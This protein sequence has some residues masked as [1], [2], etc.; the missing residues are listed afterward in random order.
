MAKFI[1]LYDLQNRKLLIAVDKIS[2]I[3][4]IPDNKNVI[5]VYTETTGFCVRGNLDNIIKA[6]EAETAIASVKHGS[7]TLDEALTFEKVHRR[8]EDSSIL[9][10]AKDVRN[11][12]DKEEK[13]HKCTGNCKSKLIEAVVLGE[14]IATQLHEVF[15]DWI[16]GNKPTPDDLVKSEKIIEKLHQFMIDEVIG[17]IEVSSKK[18]V[19]IKRNQKSKSEQQRKPRFHV[20]KITRLD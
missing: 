1:E 19:V 11:S 6:I 13:P 15:D 10:I 12:I 5:L 20:V 3:S 9:E 14:Q 4:A 17:S 7:I 18:P 8:S 16:A 2:A